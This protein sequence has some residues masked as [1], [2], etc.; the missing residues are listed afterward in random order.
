MVQNSINLTERVAVQANR[1][2][3]ILMRII[4]RLEIIKNHLCFRPPLT[5]TELKIFLYE[6]IKVAGDRLIT[7]YWFLFW[8]LVKCLFPKLIGADSQISVVL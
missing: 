4:I 5:H 3:S 1:G 6:S 2:H 8:L 7:A